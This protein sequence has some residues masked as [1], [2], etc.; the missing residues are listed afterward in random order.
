[1]HL[2]L[3]L[4]PVDGVLGCRRNTAMKL[5]AAKITLTWEKPLSDVKQGPEWWV[6]AI[7]IATNVC[8]RGSRKF[9]GEA[10]L[11]LAWTGLIMPCVC[12]CVCVCVRVCVCVY[13][14]VCVSTV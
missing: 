4:L 10:Q 7:L 12:V 3:L 8:I 9:N 13:V 11:A 2:S 14:Y 6:F 1:M 5:L